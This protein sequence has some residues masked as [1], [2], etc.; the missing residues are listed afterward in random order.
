L[1]SI[2]SGSVIAQHYRRHRHQEFLRFLKLIDTGVGGVLSGAC[3]GHPGLIAATAASL[4]SSAV[5]HSL[6]TGTGYLTRIAASTGRVPAAGLMDLAAAGAS[7]G[8]AI[9]L[10]PVLRKHSEGLALGAVVFRAIEA[11]MYTVGAVITLSLP[12]VAQQYAQA[13]APGHGRIQA[14]GDA[15]P[16]VRQ[17]AILVGVLAYILGALMYYS[18]LYRS[19]LLP[20]WLPGWG[21]A[22][23]ALMLIACMLAAFSRTPVTSYTILILPIA[24]QEIALAAWLIL[25]GFSPR[26]HA[27]PRSHRPGVSREPRRRL[28]A[29]TRPRPEPGPTGPRAIIPPSGQESPAHGPHLRANTRALI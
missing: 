11:A 4:A 2:A 5:E 24:V 1:L 20:R 15:L 17:D 6:L 7:A 26:S 3:R 22:A 18:V 10:Y 14:I 13:V 8:I 23:E 12:G 9:S 27:G 21:I 19:R 28:T 25:R 16:G 29:T